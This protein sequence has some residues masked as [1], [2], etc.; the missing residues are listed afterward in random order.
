MEKSFAMRIAADIERSVSSKK[1]TKETENFLIHWLS[2]AEKS[3]EDREVF[4]LLADKNVLPVTGMNLFRGC[5]KLLDGTVE[6]YSNS[7]AEAASFAGDNGLIIAVDTSRYCLKTFALSDYLY[8][9]CEEII[10]GTK[11]NCFSEEFVDCVEERSNED[12]VLMAT[13]LSCSVIMRIEA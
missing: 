10:A 11:E 3:S 12:E 6:S 5:K 13:D 4:R 9:L 7:V 2:D 1:I 8:S